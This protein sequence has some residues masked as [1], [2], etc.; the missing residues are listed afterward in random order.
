LI[1]ENGGCSES[2]APQF[3]QYSQQTIGDCHPAHAVVDLQAVGL[4]GS[5]GI[6]ALVELMRETDAPL[7]FTG[8]LGNRVVERPL[9][10]VGFTKM[11]DIRPGLDALRQELRS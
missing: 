7:Y 8:V 10:L 11:L 1:A 9:E 4:L 6:A 2:T 5:S 3:A